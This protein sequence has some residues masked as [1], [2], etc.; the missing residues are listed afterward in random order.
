MF[1][2]EQQLHDAMVNKNVRTPF[3]NGK[4]LGF[5]QTEKGWVCTIRADNGEIIYVDADFV[6]AFE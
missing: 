4:A 5:N 6:V 3:G 1:D 2:N